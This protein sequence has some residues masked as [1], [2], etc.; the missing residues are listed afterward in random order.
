MDAGGAHR[1]APRDGRERGAV[2]MEAAFV[3]PIVIMLVFGMVTYGLALGQ[4]NAID[5]AA[6]ESSRFGATH[7]VTDV[8]GW[9]DSVSA[10]AIAAS[11][12]ELG[13]NAPD[14]YICV[15]IAN[16]ET[17]NGRKVMVGTSAPS[18]S[19][20][21]D[22]PGTPCPS[23]APCVQVVLSRTATLDAV[24]FQRAITLKSTNVSAYERG[25]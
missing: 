16:R 17:N 2:M 9:L 18:Y 24:A 12:G 1:Q 4:R 13:D 10:V 8:N 3:F 5:N 14:R 22:C 20:S 11:T 23:T 7:P 21:G 6:R 25:A 19:T 15:A